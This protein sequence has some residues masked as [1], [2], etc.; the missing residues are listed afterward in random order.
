V[1]QNDVEFSSV[2]CTFL[3][4]IKG[5]VMKNAVKLLCTA[6]LLLS[7]FNALAG[8]KTWAGNHSAATVDD[9]LS[10]LQGTFA[11]GHRGFGSNLGENPE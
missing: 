9:F 4:E 7:T 3:S 2:L 8:G 10:D 1:L 11:I 6:L 5:S